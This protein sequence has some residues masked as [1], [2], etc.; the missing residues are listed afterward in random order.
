MIK[1]LFC[2]CLIGMFLPLL[3]FKAAQGI[4]VVYDDKKKAVNIQWQQRMPGIRSFIIQRS[5]N[6]TD[7][8]DIALQQI[9]NF[10]ASKVFQ[11][12]DYKSAAGENYYRLKCISQ[13]GQEEYSAS[14]MVITNTAANSWV[15]Y[16]VPV[17]DVLTLQYKGAQ[18]I[19]GVVNVFIA[20][21]TGRIITRI[22]S[23]SLNTIISIPVNNLGSG[24]YD[25]RIVIEEEVVWNQRFVK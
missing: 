5:S 8:T 10:N 20:N 16:P 15:M 14:V 3:A 23:S 9:A 18:K 4:R 21:I 22:R 11:Y 24:I 25:V 7:W 17:K 6:N 12:Y 13:N 1:T 19:S 2:F